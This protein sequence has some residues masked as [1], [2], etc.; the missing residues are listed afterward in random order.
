L[1]ATAIPFRFVIPVACS[2]LT[3]GARIV[4]GA[5]LTDFASG[6]ASGRREVV[7]TL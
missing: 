1:S 6:A 3:V 4:I 7:R 5:G 2:A